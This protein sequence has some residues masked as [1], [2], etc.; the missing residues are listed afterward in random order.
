[1]V[2]PAQQGLI[3]RIT[4]KPGTEYLYKCL[5]CNYQMRSV[6]NLPENGGPDGTTNCRPKC[7]TCGEHT[8]CGAQPQLL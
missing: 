1:M 6:Y 3:G 5:K 7:P 2:S 8:I 4:I